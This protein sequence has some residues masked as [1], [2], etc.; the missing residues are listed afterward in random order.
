MS[1]CF[2]DFYF[3][4]ASDMR[5]T[6]RCLNMMSSQDPQRS[7]PWS[8]VWCQ[9]HVWC[10]QIPQFCGHHSFSPGPLWTLGK[11]STWT[12]SMCSNRLSVMD[13][14]HGEQTFDC[15]LWTIVTRLVN[16]D[17]FSP[18]QNSNPTTY[19]RSRWWLRVWPHTGSK[20]ILRVGHAVNQGVSCGF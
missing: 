8:Q 5:L 1:S 14:V 19:S 17:G 13:I 16:T 7:W 15:L 4:L 20:C 18:T 12:M 6:S 10:R 11:C 9:V 3:D 2:L